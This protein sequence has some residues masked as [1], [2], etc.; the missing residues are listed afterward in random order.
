MRK[1]KVGFPT[2]VLPALVLPTLVLPTLVLPT[3]VLPTLAS[4]ASVLLDTELEG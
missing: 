1:T 3:L 2:L 4:Y